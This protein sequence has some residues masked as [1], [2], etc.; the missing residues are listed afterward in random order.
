[1]KIHLLFQLANCG[2][3]FP[4]IFEISIV[5]IVLKRPLS[6][7]F[8]LISSSAIS[9]RK[10]KTS[11]ANSFFL[12]VRY[13]SISGG[14]KTIRT[15][16]SVTSPLSSPIW[17]RTV[18]SEAPFSLEILPLSRSGTRRF[19]ECSWRASTWW[20]AGAGWEWT[21]CYSFKVLFCLVL[22]DHPKI[23][24]I[25]LEQSLLFTNRTDQVWV[26]MVWYIILKHT[27]IKL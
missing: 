21:V 22:N 7:T 18:L 20:H 4:F 25:N 6:L 12:Y 5:S 27:K 13:V 8:K 2:I 9:K 24:W 14:L 1:M 19:G 23:C 10:R 17:D 16:H 26:I 11:N 15:M 3:R